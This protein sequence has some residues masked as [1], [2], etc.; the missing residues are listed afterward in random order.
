MDTG[1][2][3]LLYMYLVEIRGNGKVYFQQRK[4][5]RSGSGGKE[6]TCLNNEK[7]NSGVTSF[8]KKPTDMKRDAAW[9]VVVYSII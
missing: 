5:G 9:S 8:D 1:V 2:G 4:S 7:G 6:K 3:G